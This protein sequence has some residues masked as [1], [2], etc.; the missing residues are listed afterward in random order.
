[1]RTILMTL[2]LLMLLT[3]C[4]GKEDVP[5]DPAA[6]G[7]E[8][9]AQVA[10]GEEGSPAASKDVSVVDDVI[11]SDP[12]GTIELVDGTVYELTEVEKIDRYYIYISGKLNGRSSTVISL[13]RLDD[14]IKWKAIVFKDPHTFAIVGRQGKKIYF[15]DSDIYFGSD[16]YHSISFQTT[17]PGKYTTQLMTVDKRDLKAIV[18]NDPVEKPVETLK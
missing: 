1:M 2:M 6:G 3:G 16:D 12:V 10:E 14:L 5:A 15:A 7:D 8:Q 9:A 4:A 17:L 13:T 11:K 18:F